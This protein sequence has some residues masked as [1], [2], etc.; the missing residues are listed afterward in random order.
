MLC[1]TE[2]TLSAYSGL[3]CHK[4]L[5]IDLISLDYLL[6]I[7]L[8]S[9]CTRIVSIGLV[10][11]QDLQAHLLCS[12]DRLEALSQP[13]KTGWGRR[14][15][16]NCTLIR[17]PM[18]YDAAVSRQLLVSVFHRSMRVSYLNLCYTPTAHCPWT[19]A[20]VNT[21]THIWSCNLA[22]DEHLNPAGLT[23]YCNTCVNSGMTA[24][25][26]FYF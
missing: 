3:K 15:K 12:N 16:V 25:G 5:H 22:K 13:I 14:P 1:R 20:R 26:G 7:K 2:N 8:S 11:R 21:H 24:G 23:W 10:V 19:H 18:R 4:E 9:S 6:F 17:L